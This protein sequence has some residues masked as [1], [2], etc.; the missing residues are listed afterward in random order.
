MNS[1]HETDAMCR[2]WEDLTSGIFELWSATERRLTSI[3]EPIVQTVLFILH[4]SKSVC[5]NNHLYSTPTQRPY[6]HIEETG[7]AALYPNH[8]TKFSLIWLRAT[9]AFYDLI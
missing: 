9:F 4:F 1:R 3:E 7:D 5:H 2:S 8:E 6:R